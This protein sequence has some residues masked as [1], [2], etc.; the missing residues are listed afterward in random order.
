MEEE[1]LQPARAVRL[2]WPSSLPERVR[3]VRDYLLKS[4]TPAQPETV[5]RSFTRARLPEVQAILD[6]LT[7]LGQASRQDNGYRS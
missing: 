2:P 3:A 5:A 7:A 6:T 4:A 1:E